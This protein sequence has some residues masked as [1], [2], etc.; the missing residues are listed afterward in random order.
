MPSLCS[1]SDDALCLYHDKNLQRDKLYRNVG[2]VTVLDLCKLSGDALYLYKN[3]LK[4]PQRVSELLSGHEIMTKI[5]IG[6]NSVQN[7]NVG[8]VTVLGLCTSCADALYLH[9]IS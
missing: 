5:Y 1:S 6:L 3:F 9:Q 7:E 4:I 2:G 8:E